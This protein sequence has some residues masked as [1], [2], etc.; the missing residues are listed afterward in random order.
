MSV[1]FRIR[2]TDLKRFRTLLEREKPEPGKQWIVFLEITQ[3]VGIFRV[4]K[5]KAEYPVDGASQGFGKVPE[6]SVWRILLDVLDKRKT[7]E[8]EIVVNDGYIRCESNAVS[9]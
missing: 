8:V 9:D 6:E 5:V 1:K 3:H 7:G 4:G 2:R